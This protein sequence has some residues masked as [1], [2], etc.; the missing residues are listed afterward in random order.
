MEKLTIDQ[1]K[2]VVDWM[3][4]WDQLKNSSIPIR[5]AEDWTSKLDKPNIN[6]TFYSDNA[7]NRLKAKYFEIGLKESK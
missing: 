7:I 4:E 2:A 3:N 6:G 1:I 5:F